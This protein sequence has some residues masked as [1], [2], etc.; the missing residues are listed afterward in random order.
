[1]MKYMSN[2][3]VMIIHL[4]V[5]IIKMTLFY[6]ISYFPEPF[7]YTLNKMRFDLNWTNFAQ[8]LILQQVLIH[9]NL[10]KKLN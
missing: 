7:N 4:T 5:G 1:M 3:K 9:L 8:N 2:G 6:K 10:L